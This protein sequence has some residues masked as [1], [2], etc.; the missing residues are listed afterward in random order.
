MKKI[1]YKTVLSSLQILT[2][3][4][5][6]IVVVR[7]LTEEPSLWSAALALIVAVLGLVNGIKGFKELTKETRKRK[8]A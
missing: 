4:L 2:G 7:C 3:V 1:I 5:A 6:A 8:Q